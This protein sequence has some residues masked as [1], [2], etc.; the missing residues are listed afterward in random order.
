MIHTD[1]SEYNVLVDTE[2]MVWIIDWPQYVSADHPNALELLERDIGNVVYYFKRKYGLEY[3][4]DQALKQV[5][6]SLSASS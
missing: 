4:Q 6:G 5:M 1:L 2:G 3:D